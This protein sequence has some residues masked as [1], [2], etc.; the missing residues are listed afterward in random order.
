MKS[1]KTPFNLT[2]GRI[3][4]TTDYATIVE[5]KI[6]DVLVTGKL[7]RPTLPLYGVGLQELLFENIDELVEADIRTDAGLE[8][9][10]SVS[11]VKILD[12]SIRQSELEESATVVKVA[13]QIGQSAPQVLSF[14]VL[15]TNLT[16]ES[17]F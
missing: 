2:G 12:I 10:E 3:A 1:L 13:Y 17:P 16:E 8:L 14:Q 6:R 7:E 11:G 15:T 5:Q 4:T 9:L